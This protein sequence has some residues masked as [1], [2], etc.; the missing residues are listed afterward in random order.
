MRKIFKEKSSDFLI[1]KAFLRN[2]KKNF[3]IYLMFTD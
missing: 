1:E 2:A 3:L